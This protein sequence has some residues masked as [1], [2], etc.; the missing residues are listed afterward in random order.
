MRQILHLDLDAFFAAVEQR[1]DPNI[2]GRPVLVGGSSRRG[3]VAAAS[4]EAREFGVHSAMPMVEALRRCPHAVVIAG[5]REAYTEAS[6]Q[7]FAIF[8]RYTPLVEGLSID[9]AFLDVTASQSLFGNG[10]EIARRIRAEIQQEVRLT[11]SAGV[12]PNKFLAKIASELDKPDGM[13]V[14]P[15]E[16]VRAFLDPL[17]I[18]RMW[19]VGPKAAR[20]LHFAGFGTIGDLARADVNQLE[21]LLGSWGVCVH[22]LANGIDDREVQP[23]HVAKSVGAE[24]TFEEDLVVREDLERHLLSQAQRVARRLWISGLCAGTVVV[25]IKYADFA[26]RTRQTRLPEPVYDTDSI[27]AAAKQLLGQFALQGKRVRLTGVAVA[28]LRPGPPPRSLFPD[29]DRERRQRIEEV[30]NAIRQRFGSHSVTRATLV[31]DPSL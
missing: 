19:G 25:K 4:Y 18:E 13:V 2:K 24:A 28:D 7:V 10:V 8:R 16:E 26:L 14:V 5:R 15:E 1:D 31:E 3:V 11:A 6:E 22:R 20:R 29:P 30:S 21:S 23:G 12:A 27:Y 17:P 9:E